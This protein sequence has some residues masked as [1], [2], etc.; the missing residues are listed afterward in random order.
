MSQYAANPDSTALE[1][2]E[3][4]DFTGPCCQKF[5]PL[6]STIFPLFEGTIRYHFRHFSNLQ[7][8]YAFP[9]A[10]AA[11]AARRQDQ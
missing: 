2:M 8:P 4:G 5:Q 6:L 9:M 10:L 3:Y 7:H 11:E 1:L